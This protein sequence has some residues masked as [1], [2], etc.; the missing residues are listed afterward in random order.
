M[1]NIIVSKTGNDQTGNGA[2][3]SPFLTIQRAVKETHPGDV[4]MPRGGTYHEAFN[5][6][7]AGGK[8]GTEKA[9]IKIMPYPGEH[10]VIDGSGL[11]FKGGALSFTATH[12][13]DVEGLEILNLDGLGI[14]GNVGSSHLTF[15]D[16]IVHKTGQS[17][18]GFQQCK[19]ITLSNPEV[20]DTHRVNPSNG[21]ITMMGVDGYRIINQRTHDPFIN[22]NANELKEGSKNGLVS[23]GEIWGKKVEQAVYVDTYA[24]GTENVEIA[25][26]CAH[27]CHYGICVCSETGQDISNVRIHDNLVVR[28]G[29]GIGLW[30]TTKS[31][32]QA[33]FRSF[34]VYLNTLIKTG[35]LVIYSG[36][37]LDNC[38]FY[39]NRTDKNVWT[40]RKDAAI[41]N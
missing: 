5:V 39:D 40:F 10:P 18:I 41:F 38:K 21:M 14:Y 30:R 37:V 27:D 19:E 16:V 24:G 17:G 20:Y 7:D 4:I 1:A 28:A 2:E 13:W 6:Y 9:H 26:V 29:E 22:R 34:E 35:G 25:G 23:G 36:P 3:L 8:S 31:S 33:T 15:K 11:G 32:K 12:W